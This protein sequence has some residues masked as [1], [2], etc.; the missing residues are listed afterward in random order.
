VHF[1]WE[2]LCFPTPHYSVFLVSQHLHRIK[3]CQDNRLLNIYWS[4]IVVTTNQ[5]GLSIEESLRAYTSCVTLPLSQSLTFTIWYPAN[6]FFPY[7][8]NWQLRHFILHHLKVKKDL[9]GLA[10]GHKRFNSFNKRCNQK[11]E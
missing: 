11:L 10:K 7:S 6:Y 5:L 2:L 4:L 9:L 3:H 8:L 1:V